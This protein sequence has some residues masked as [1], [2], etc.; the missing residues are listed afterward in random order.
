MSAK[1]QMLSDV[2]VG[3]L[4]YG[5]ADGGQPKLLL[6]FEAD[7]SSFYARHVTSQTIA[8]FGRDGE[9]LS[10]PD[11]GS[12]TIVSTASLPREQYDVAIALDRRMAS[13]PAYPDTRLTEDEIQLILTHKEFYE[14]RLLPGTEAVVKRAQKLRLVEKLLLRDWDPVRAQV[15]PPSIDEYRAD[16]PALIDLLDGG[17]TRSDVAAHLAQLAIEHGRLSIVSGRT[18]AA[19]AGLLRLTEDWS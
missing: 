9:S 8:K 16:V 6:I 1:A 19:A 5:I 3:D 18:D 14:S 4:V 13:N 17:P 12:C 7:S 15:A 10:T 11:G 2:K